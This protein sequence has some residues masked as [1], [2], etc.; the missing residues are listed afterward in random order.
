VIRGSP[1]QRM[2]WD[3]GYLGRFNLDEHREGAFVGDVWLHDLGLSKTPE[4]HGVQWLRD[5]RIALSSRSNFV[6]AGIFHA[7]ELV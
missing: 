3:G 5:A 7:S 6:A 2:E 4:H 1:V